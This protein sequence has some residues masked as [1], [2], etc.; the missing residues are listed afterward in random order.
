MC[1]CGTLI[2]DNLFSCIES[3][4]APQPECLGMK[5]RWGVFFSF[6]LDAHLLFGRHLFCKFVVSD[7][8]DSTD[9]GGPVAIEDKSKNPG[10]EIIVLFARHH[11]GEFTTI[12]ARGNVFAHAAGS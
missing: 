10:H 4:H 1:E 3:H 7:G 12:R 8:L 6:S 2:S 11:I 5:S 9:A